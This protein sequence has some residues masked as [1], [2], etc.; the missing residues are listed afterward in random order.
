MGSLVVDAK[1]DYDDHFPASSTLPARVGTA[2]TTDTQATGL[3]GVEFRS[4]SAALAAGLTYN[5]LQGLREETTPDISE[6]RSDQRQMN[7]GFDTPS[8][9]LMPGSSAL[10]D[11]PRPTTSNLDR[12]VAAEHLSER[13]NLIDALTGIGSMS[14]TPMASPIY[15]NQDGFSQGQ[16][17]HEKGYVDTQSESESESESREV[18]AKESSNIRD[19]GIPREQESAFWFK[20][21]KNGLSSEENLSMRAMHKLYKQ[22][23]SGMVQRVSLDEDDDTFSVGELVSLSSRGL[24]LTEAEWAAVFEEVHKDGKVLYGDLMKAV[25]KCV[26]S[27]PLTKFKD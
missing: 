5:D 10:R 2:T 6:D 15:S 25:G 1:D 21:M 19:S 9:D 4:M 8:T 14:A 27:S 12:R 24:E 26:K 16:S 22:L 17:Q 7:G 13:G 11:L 20:L 23:M 3:S 18:S